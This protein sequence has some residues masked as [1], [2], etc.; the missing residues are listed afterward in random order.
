MP[1]L[2]DRIDGEIIE[3]AHMNE[4]T[5]RSVQR[6]ADVAERDALNPAPETG[7]P[8]WIIADSE[9][10]I[11]N[12]TSWIVAGAGVFLPISGGI[13]G[14]YID[15]NNHN[16]DGVPRIQGFDGTEMILT[17][18]ANA[19]IRVQGLSGQGFQVLPAATGTIM[20]FLNE[21]SNP[22]LEWNTTNQ[23]VVPSGIAFR[24][25]R[26]Y[27]S[28]TTDPA[29]MVIGSTG[30][31]QR[32]TA[33]LVTR[34]ELDAVEQRIDELESQITTLENAVA[35]HEIR[36]SALEGGMTSATIPAP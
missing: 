22:V 31:I 16:L 17:P 7:Q 25:L 18:G 33:V 27:E 15:M 13:M 20:R 35:D 14:G 26:A 34:D 2:P 32:S 21:S 10:H 36:I 12:G 28:T 6:Y 9:L 29:N 5:I 24:I 30:F 23:W 11:F 19:G 8:A 3:A 1:E 4:A